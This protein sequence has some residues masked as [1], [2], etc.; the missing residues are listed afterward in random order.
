MR[1]RIL[2]SVG[3]A[4]DGIEVGFCAFDADDRTIVWNRTFLEL[5]PEHAGFVH[6]G[7]PYAD[8]LRRFYAG[9]LTGSER[10]NIEHYVA[11]GVQRHRE[12]QR[13]Y[14]FDH[15]SGRVRVSSIEI[16]RHGRLRLWRPVKPLAQRDP[17]ATPA[18]SALSDVRATKVLEHLCDGVLVVGPTDRSLW[19]NPAFLHLY[20][21]ASVDDVLA[22][23]FDEIYRQRWSAEPPNEQFA[24]AARALRDNRRFSGAPFELPLPN[25]CWVRVVEER[26]DAAEGRGY[27]VHVDITPLKRQQ[28]AS[29]A[30]ERRARDSEQRYRLLAEYS[31]DITVATRAGLITYISPAVFKLLGW[32]PQ[33]MQDQPLARYCHPDDIAGVERALHGLRHTAEVEYRTRALTRDGNW[34]WTEARTRRADEA[35]ADGTPPLLVVNVRNIAA[36]KE[37]ED[38]LA[39]AHL[40]LEVLATT[41]AL[42]GLANRRRLDEVLQAECRRANREHAELALLM[43][44]ID[45]FKTLNDRLGHLAGDAVLRSVAALLVAF[46]HRAGD[47]A[48][49][50]GGE[51]LALV[52]PGTGR[53]RAA[54]VAEKL[55][56]AVERLDDAANGPSR[57]VTV[58]IGVATR[59]AGAHRTTPADLLQRADEALYAAKRDGKNR[60]VVAS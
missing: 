32:Q 58:S 42:T 41:D 33:D 15:A 21:L 25:D 20:G 1:D 43:L 37:V 50:Y 26:S 19:A 22:R 51:E 14:E 27:L 54:E 47:L 52:L 18:A 5:F 40:R 59:P 48:A 8:N 11:R 30:A 28:A 17:N 2:R 34:V 12:Q 57:R 36:R 23:S 4:L 45:D 16:G 31:S 13:P 53:V 44:D 38:Q 39:A 9:R 60:V 55:R 7:E 46:A 10:E 24:A 35:Q 56:A 6:A 49:R 3:A 29:M